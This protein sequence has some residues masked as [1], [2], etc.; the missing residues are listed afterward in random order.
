MTPTEV[1]RR[2][3]RLHPGFGPPDEPEDHDLILCRRHDVEFP[4]SSH[5]HYCEEGER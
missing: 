3:Q 2:L 1:L 4:R 5:C